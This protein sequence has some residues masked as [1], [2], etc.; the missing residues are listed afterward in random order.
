MFARHGG[1]GVQ[2]HD[3]GRWT[4]EFKDSLIYVS[5]TTARAKQKKPCLETPP[6]PKKK[7]GVKGLCVLTFVAPAIQISSL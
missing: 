3:G 7:T 1:T 2:S 4:S 6:P 5:S